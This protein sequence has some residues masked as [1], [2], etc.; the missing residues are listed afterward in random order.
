MNKAP[1]VKPIQ[2]ENYREIYVTGQIGIT[3]LIKKHKVTSS[4]GLKGVGHD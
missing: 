4:H 2:A 3:S 1:D